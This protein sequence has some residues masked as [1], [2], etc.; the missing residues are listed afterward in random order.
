MPKDMPQC[1][2]SLSGSYSLGSRILFYSCIL[3]SIASLICRGL[4]QPGQRHRLDSIIAFSVSSTLMMAFV[5]ALHTIVISFISITTAH[6]RYVTDLDSIAASYFARTGH[7]AAYIFLYWW[8]YEYSAGQY[9]IFQG[10]QAIFI[11][12]TISQPIAAIKSSGAAAECLGSGLQECLA[13]CSTYTAPLRAGS[14]PF[15]HTPQGQTLLEFVSN[16]SQM[17]SLMTAMVAY[18]ATTLYFESPSFNRSYAARM[19]FNIVA[20]AFLILSLVTCE[21]H[22]QRP[23][24]SI[25]QEPLSAVG[26]WGAMASA[27]LVIIWNITFLSLVNVDGKQSTLWFQV[28]PNLY[29][30]DELFAKPEP[31]STQL[32]KSGRGTW[33]DSAAEV[34]LGQRVPSTP[35]L[36][37]VGS[38]P[39]ADTSARFRRRRS[40][41]VARQG[42]LLGSGGDEVVIEMDQSPALI[43]AARRPYAAHSIKAARISRAPADAGRVEEE[44]EEQQEKAERTGRAGAVENDDGSDEWIDQDELEVLPPP[45]VPRRK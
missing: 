32:E 40:S 38:P 37:P 44:D 4:W 22:F 11:A 5:A 18:V 3:S 24:Y 2:F 31:T 13:A 8:P 28:N 36:D 21:I 9:M 19:A 30:R 12:S 16:I 14:N 33:R 25:G 23:P 29:P 41:S 20:V 26:Q 43:P 1:Y 35:F 10:A 7:V 17:I 42:G 15:P 45:T 6:Y 39:S 27:A 34:E